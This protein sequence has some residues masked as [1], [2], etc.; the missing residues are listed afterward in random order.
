MGR[1]ESGLISWIGF[2]SLSA[3]AE[4]IRLVTGLISIEMTCMVNFRRIGLFLSLA[5][6]VHDR[7]NFILSFISLM[8]NKLHS[9]L[10]VYR[11]TITSHHSPNPAKKCTNQ[12]PYKIVPQSFLSSLLIT[13]AS[14]H[15]SPSLPPTHSKISSSVDSPAIIHEHDFPSHLPLGKKKIV[16]RFAP[17]NRSRVSLV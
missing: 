14:I 12:H 3:L 10:K 7:P 13:S 8:H 2:I 4:E 6:T 9:S 16:S 11:L 5:F 17:V 15:Y 1:N